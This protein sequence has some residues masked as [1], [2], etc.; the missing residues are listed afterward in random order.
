MPKQSGPKYKHA[1]TNTEGSLPPAEGPAGN[2]IGGAM[3]LRPYGSGGQKAPAGKNMRSGS[4]GGQR[5]PV[6]KGMK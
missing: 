4:G 3:T 2:Q 1:R 6:G 5:S